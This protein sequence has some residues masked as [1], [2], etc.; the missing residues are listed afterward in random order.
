MRMKY[1]NSKDRIRSEC[2]IDILLSLD[3]G[4][5]IGQNY[6]TTS[7]LLHRIPCIGQ[8]LHSLTPWTAARQRV[9]SWRGATEW[10]KKNYRG[11]AT[12]RSISAGWNLLCYQPLLYCQ[13]LRPVGPPRHSLARNYAEGFWML[14]YAGGLWVFSYAAGLWMGYGTG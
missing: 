8:Y 13:P 5:R 12:P 1:L 7:S 11:G 10:L 2:Y 6:Q 3:Y 14:S 4:E 9:A